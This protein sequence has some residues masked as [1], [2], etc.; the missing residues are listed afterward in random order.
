[1]S[2]FIDDYDF[3]EL[4]DDYE[5]PFERSETIYTFDEF[6]A[7][8]MQSLDRSYSSYVDHLAT[9]GLREYRKAEAQRKE[10]QRRIAAGE[11]PFY[12]FKSA[13]PKFWENMPKDMFVDYIP[14]EEPY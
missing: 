5:S 9:A 11:K 1:M 4:Y 12:P 13:P 7:F 10:K 6:K 8:E 3:Q 2:N 14:P